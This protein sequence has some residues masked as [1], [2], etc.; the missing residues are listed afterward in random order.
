MERSEYMPRPVPDGETG[1]RDL[2][3]AVRME[4]TQNGGGSGISEGIGTGACPQ[5]ACVGHEGCGEGSWGVNGYPLAMVL[6]P[7]QGYRALYD[8]ATALSRG[9]LFTELDLP[10][11]CAEAAF[12]T[13]CACRAE[14][15]GS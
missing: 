5:R 13:G 14:R 1:A 2:P 4:A 9:T 15:R 11:G 6:S 10:L 3:P 8:P 12:T 7:C